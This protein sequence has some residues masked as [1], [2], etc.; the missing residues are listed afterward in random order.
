MVRE[1]AQPSHHLSIVGVNCRMFDVPL[2]AMRAVERTNGS[3]PGFLYGQVVDDGFRRGRDLCCILCELNL[4][5]FGNR[6]VEGNGVSACSYTDVRGG[7]SLR[8]CQRLA[9]LCFDVPVCPA[10]LFLA[11]RR[12]RRGRNRWRALSERGSGW[13]LDQSE[14]RNVLR[15]ADGLPVL[16]KVGDSQ[17]ELERVLRS[18]AWHN[19]LVERLFRLIRDGAV[20]PEAVL[21][22]K[23]GFA[24]WLFDRHSLDRI[25]SGESI[26]G[27]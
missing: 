6:A 19:V 21:N 15:I 2:G 24:G 17:V 7:E 23:R 26:R 13:V 12:C 11:D 18:C 10:R 3:V 1:G 9:D 4:I 8:P 14:A 16:D 22:G 5:L 27:L 25:K 20:K